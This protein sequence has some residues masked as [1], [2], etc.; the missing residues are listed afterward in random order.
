MCKDHCDSVA[1]H[2]TLSTTPSYVTGSEV[3]ARPEHALSLNDVKISFFLQFISFFKDH[4]VI[5]LPRPFAMFIGTFLVLLLG[6]FSFYYIMLRYTQMYK[7]YMKHSII[8][9]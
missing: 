5:Y 9:Q 2:W 4:E 6:F 1:R 8:K 7:I 3:S